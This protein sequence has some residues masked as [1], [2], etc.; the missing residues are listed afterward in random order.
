[1]ITHIVEDSRSAAKQGGKTL[2]SR[3]FGRY[4]D[5]IRM[6]IMKFAVRALAIFALI[7]PVSLSG[8]SGTTG[9][10][11]D[12]A[13]A[14]PSAGRIVFDMGH[15][16]IFGADDTSDLGQSQAIAKMR[17]AGFE[18][19]VNPDAITAEDLAD[20]SGLV[21]AGPMRP[22]LDEE[23]DAITAF[24]ERGGTVLLTIH[25]PFPVLKVPA[26]WGLPVDTAIVMSRRPF[27]SPAEPS[28]FIADGIAADTPVTAGVDEIL[29]VSGWPV[30]TASESGRLAVMTGA[31]SWLTSAGDQQPIPPEGTVFSSYGIIGITQVGKG[32][33]VV[34]G[35]DAV[36]ANIA[37]GM[38]D[39]AKLLENII[40]LMSEMQKV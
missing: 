35:D 29:V 36:F 17:S 39:N 1:V 2:Q 28:V 21:I 38:A 13:E 15:G 9:P 16:E 3:R 32:L 8:C 27:S 5:A 6:T 12:D 22:L 10:S 25:V 30:G 40:D 37:L 14:L 19:A 33:I 7:L 31:D 26:H 24:A 34:S 4:L 20:A 11:F 18:V 23:Y